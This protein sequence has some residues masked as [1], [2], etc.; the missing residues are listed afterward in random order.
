MQ[1]EQTITDRIDKRQDWMVGPYNRVK[2][3]KSMLKAMGFWTPKSKRRI[4]IAK[5][6]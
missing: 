1:K 4:R 5:A 6:A 2:G 3:P